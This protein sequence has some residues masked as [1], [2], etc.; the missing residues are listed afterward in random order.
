MSS[1]MPTSNLTYRAEIIRR[2]P[3]GGSSI[4]Y[5]GGEFA[6]YCVESLMEVLRTESRRPH[7][8]LDVSLELKGACNVTTVRD[9]A[10]KFTDMHEPRMH[11]RISAPGHPGVIISPDLSESPKQAAGSAAAHAGQKTI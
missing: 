8:M 7:E 1:L 9:L 6:P 4:Y 5:D 2:D 11:V 10:R 3:R